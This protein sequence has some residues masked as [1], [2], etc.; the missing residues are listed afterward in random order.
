MVVICNCWEYEGSELIVLFVQTPDS[1][2][3]MMELSW[4]GTKTVSLNNGETRKFIQV[5]VLFIAIPSKH[6]PS[7]QD[8][9]E[10]VITG[11]CQGDGYRVGFGSCSGKVLPA[12]PLEEFIAP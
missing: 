3:S 1:L 9:D 6:F 5:R 12:L 2:G 8:N 11:W 7:Q 4:R 10:V